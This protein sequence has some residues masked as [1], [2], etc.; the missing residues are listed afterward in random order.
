MS[1]DKK[2]ALK[3]RNK[4]QQNECR[5]KW[6]KNK[7]K[8]ESVKSTARK[9]KMR[10]RSNESE[11]PIRTTPRKAFGSC[12]SFGRAL[13]KA[14]SALPSSPRKKAV[15][16][17]ELATKFNI[18]RE[19]ITKTIKPVS[20]LESA[21]VDFYGSDQ[22]SWQMPG[23]RD[24]VTIR[25]GE[26]KIKVQKKV[27]LCTVME[28]YH[29]FRKENTDVKIGKS[30]FASL[31][32][33]H[34]VPVSDKDHN[35]CCCVYHENFD[36]L[37]EG[38]RKVKP[39]LPS[40]KCLLHM[41]VCDPENPQCYFGKCDVCVNIEENVTSKV[42]ATVDA[43]TRCD[44]LQWD[45]RNKKKV[46]ELSIADAKTEFSK[47][48]TIL[49]K[50]NFIAKTQLH[51]KKH[52]KEK[53]ES[54]EIILQ[55]DFSENFAIKQQ[56]EIMSAHWD[57]QGV[58]V[59]T[60]VVTTQSG[61]QSYAIISDELRHDKFAV[62][63]YNRT[64]LDHA[65]TSGIDVSK[66]H[67]F[68]DGAGGQFK[69]RF[70]LSLL[71]QP[72]LLHADAE[73]I[74]WSFFATAHGKGPVDGVGGT[75]KRAVWRRVLQRKALVN[76]SK[77]FAAVAEAAC[78]NIHVIHVESEKVNKVREE[79]SALWSD[80]MPK[81]IPETRNY[82]FFAPVSATD[83]KVALI[84]PFLP[85][86]T[87]E[88]KTVQMFS[89]TANHGRAQSLPSTSLPDK[90]SC[91]NVHPGPHVLRQ[92]QQQ[93][94]VDEENEVHCDHMKEFERFLSLRNF[95]LHDITPGDGN[96]FFWSL[97][98]QL[99][100]QGMPSFE[101]HELR[102]M[103]CD[104]MSKLSPSE[105]AELQQFIPDKSVEQFIADMRKNGTYADHIVVEYTSRT[106]ADL[107]ITVVMKTSD[108]I[109]GKPDAGTPSLYIGYIPRLQHYVSLRPVPHPAMRANN[110][111]REQ[112]YAVDYIDRFYIG[113]VVRPQ[114]N[115]R[116]FSTVKFLHQTSKDGQLRFAWPKTDDIDQVYL[117]NFFFGPI[118]LEGCV[119]FTIPHLKEVQQEFE[120]LFRHA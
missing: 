46:V 78:P 39:D 103:V 117:G 18:Q 84:S 114:S 41:A 58:T 120:S 45:E 27:M 35:V 88:S 31:R 94:L 91:S 71:L 53:L 69:N 43:T 104:Y 85:E 10:Q 34:V 102:K 66:I 65:A 14:K 80:Q 60:A 75:V 93:Q 96:C 112:Y 5:S 62:A 7:R 101:P 59:F 97:K 40:S 2:I 119:E 79:L 111:E 28:A 1:H 20:A 8:A 115:L 12:Q 70:T 54:N 51:E 25:Q 55:E 86:Y 21:V 118:T 13:K 6:D 33:A 105:K 48:L 16:V 22:I 76:S 47:Q 108:T 83:M 87:V 89:T 109:I 37:L 107:A 24:F 26:T 56:G 38:M 23:R 9:R 113:R 44:F 50:H 98:S 52:L 63:A 29:A 110:V 67:V 74:D 77:D 68:S 42:F 3:E 19:E 30:K 11:T 106:L 4:Q 92:E 15:V 36:L 100:R 57:Q 17:Q 99:E 64:I 90:E 73:E 81:A 72:E 49:R 95:K 116:D 82:H 61:S 32:P